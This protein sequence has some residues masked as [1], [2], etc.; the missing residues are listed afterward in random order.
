MYKW[1]RCADNR[2]SLPDAEPGGVPGGDDEFV[3]GA[4]D[5]ADGGDEAGGDAA[6]GVSLVDV[7][8]ACPAL[9]LLVLSFTFSSM[10]DLDM[11]S[12]LFDDQ[13]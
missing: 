7:L 8:A 11:I 13:L 2:F 3:A 9:V 12:L 6:V 10:Y 5:L 4:A 1:D